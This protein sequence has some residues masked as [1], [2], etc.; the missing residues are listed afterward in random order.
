MLQNL[1]ESGFF[2]NEKNKVMAEAKKDGCECPICGQFVKVYKRTIHATMARQLIS[3]YRKNGT[4]FFHLSDVVSEGLT[5]AGDF[6]KLE[7]WGLI[8]GQQHIKG[9][10]GKRTSGIWRITDDGVA[11]LQGLSSVKKYAVVYNGRCIDM[12]GEPISIT[13]ALGK[14]FDYLELMQAVA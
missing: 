1:F 13:D 5:G 3:A 8:A 2:E 9:E 10:D 7:M 6:S 12:T 4:Q 14:N 11:F